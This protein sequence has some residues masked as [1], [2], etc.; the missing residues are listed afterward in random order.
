MY[1]FNFPAFE[2]KMTQLKTDR[3]QTSA[4]DQYWEMPWSEE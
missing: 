3:Y 1:A 2:E 4:V